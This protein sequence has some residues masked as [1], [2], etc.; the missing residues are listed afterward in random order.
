MTEKTRRL[1]LRIVVPDAPRRGAAVEVRPLVDGEDLLAGAFTEGPGEDPRDLLVPD[2]PLMATV[3]PREV[4][5]AE[6]TCTEGC[7]G[8]L[9]ATVRRD[10]DHVV[11]DRWRN[12]EKDEVGLPELRFDAGQ[13][14]A[15]VERATTDHSWEWRARTVARLLERDLRQHTDWLARWECELAGVSAWL[16]QPDRVQLFLFYPPRSTITED[17]PWL[18]FRMMLPV[19]G[20]D[21]TL[22]AAR[23]AGRLVAG[24]PRRT[25]EVCGGSPEF[26]RQLGYSWPRRPGP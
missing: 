20:E 8:A 14:R 24:D 19:S 7:C 5:L 13:Y 1:T 23:L 6:A 12:P 2:G 22:Q 21:P 15:E 16:W 3:E 11:W 25:A 18:Q 10:G 4:R 9:Y 17:R 26:A